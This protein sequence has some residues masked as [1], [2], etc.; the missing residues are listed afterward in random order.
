MMLGE[1]GISEQLRNLL[2]ECRMCRSSM[3]S[4]LVLVLAGTQG[5]EENEFYYKMIEDTNPA[6][7]KY[8]FHSSYNDFW[9]TF[10]SGPY[11]PRRR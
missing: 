6:H 1:T 4:P 5:D 10:Q 7:K 2:Y 11:S 8:D 3:T 9:M